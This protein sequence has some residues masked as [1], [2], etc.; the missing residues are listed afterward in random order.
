MD[1]FEL[2]EIG[3]PHLVDALGR[4]LEL[5]TGRDDLERRT[6]NQVIALENAIDARFGNEVF[7]RIDDVI[8]QFT[9][10]L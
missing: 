9:Q 1:D 2:R 5:I 7:P 10:I 3:L 8:C 6:G 4:V